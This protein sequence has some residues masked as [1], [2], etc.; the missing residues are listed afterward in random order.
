MK[1]CSRFNVDLGKVI[2]D[3]TLSTGWLVNVSA[4]FGRA[5]WTRALE[6]S[7]TVFLEIPIPCFV[8]VFITFSKKVVSGS[9]PLL[10]I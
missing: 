8:R 3:F 9:G 6:L 2:V 4:V 10:E 5:A 7:R 1:G